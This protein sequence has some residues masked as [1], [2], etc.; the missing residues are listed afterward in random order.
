MEYSRQE[1]YYAREGEFT[2]LTGVP[3][4]GP[5]FQTPA[6]ILVSINNE[7]IVHVNRRFAATSP[8]ISIP[9]LNTTLNENDT[10]YDLL[11]VR[12]NNPPTII[13]SMAEASVPKI[14]PASTAGLTEEDC[15]F[16]FDDGAVKV[17][18]GT[19]ITLQIEAEQPDV[20]NV[21]N[22]KLIIKPSKAELLYQW[23]FNGVAV[24]LFEKDDSQRATKAVQGSKLIIT[25]MIPK[26]AGLYNCIVSN[27]IG[28]TDGGSIN[29]EVYNSDVDDL[30]YT[31][32]VANPNGLAEDGTLSTSGWESVTGEFASVPLTQNTS[33]ERDKRIVT[34]PFNSKVNWTQEMMAPRPYQINKGI[35][36]NN[37]LTNIRSYFTRQK[38]QY[39]FNE[40]TTVMQVYQD[41]DLTELEDQ[42]KGSIYGVSGVGAVVSCY[43]GMA[44]YNYEPAYPHISPDRRASPFSY[45]LGSARLSFQNFYKTGPGFVKERAYVD[46]EEYNKG[47]RV[48]SI[49][50]GR[51]QNEPIRILD[52]WNSR[53]PKYNNRVYYQGGQDLLN[54]DGPSTGDNRDR[55]LWVADELFPT[56]ESR[57]TFGQYAEFNK[58]IIDKLNPKTN[59]IRLV[60]TI[61]SLSSLD[62]TIYDRGREIHKQI[63]DG[64]L[65]CPGWDGSWESDTA[66]NKSN[67]N[68]RKVF[69]YIA[70]TY[71]TDKQWP[72]SIEERVPKASDSRALATG[73]NVSLIPLEV[74]RDNQSVLKNTYTLNTKVERLIPSPVR[75]LSPYIAGDTG[76]RDL[77]ITF[78]LANGTEMQIQILATIPNLP[79]IE[80]AQ[81]PYSPGLLPLTV[82]SNVQLLFAPRVK[83]PLAEQRHYSF[84]GV[85]AS[86]ETDTSPVTNI[87]T[88]IP[89]IAP[90]Y[91]GGGA[92]SYIELD[93]RGVNLGGL[94]LVEEVR[95][96]TA[97][98]LPLTWYTITNLDRLALVKNETPPTRLSYSKWAIPGKPLAYQQYSDDW[99][100]AFGAVLS[101]GDPGDEQ[102]FILPTGRTRGL[103]VENRIWNRASRFLITIGVHNTNEPEQIQLTGPFGLS[104]VS[105]PNQSHLHAIDN[106]YLDFIENDVVIHKTALIFP[107]FGVLPSFDVQERPSAEIIEDIDESTSNLKPGGGNEIAT[108]VKL[109]SGAD[110]PPTAIG[111]SPYNGRENKFYINMTP[112]TIPVSTAEGDSSKVATFELPASFLTQ[113]RNLGGLNIPQITNEQGETVP[114]PSYKVYIYGIRPVPFGNIIKD[115]VG[116]TAPLGPENT[117][118]DRVVG[119]PLSGQ[120]IVSGRSYTIQNLAVENLMVNTNQG[121]EN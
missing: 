41:I 25:N 68:D 94:E 29:L 65:E 107:N 47:K 82:N 11:P 97:P 120:D 74:G 99:Q 101:D 45:Y 17:H 44:I 54:P 85:L 18:A 27:D 7:T 86:P 69:N 20:L 61:E 108:G 119:T 39:A 30:F 1:Q 96:R 5:Y 24:P 32:L 6:G 55:H 48:P 53:L 76:L 80:T 49:Y 10:E 60:D 12:I 109:L 84:A 50:Q 73:F 75:D 3:Y 34:D 88:T 89:T 98:R 116:A 13:R 103:D 104:E 78:R 90:Y 66:E 33:G 35:L 102:A 95:I 112:I 37:S 81:V 64:I 57:Y 118:S 16:L 87:K 58:I 4:V 114:D 121:A 117:S 26:W 59:K 111:P 105:I 110:Y 52:P 70:S 62:F 42:I 14:K 106:Y 31:N 63:T 15:M 72:N 91:V 38:Y 93:P 21:E 43:L 36:R 28:P 100:K 19:T 77:D 67:A 22:G 83:S 113:A 71:R 2:T 9:Q 51:I 40:G 23:T 115:Y 92:Y 56:Q 46:V 79:Q 8:P